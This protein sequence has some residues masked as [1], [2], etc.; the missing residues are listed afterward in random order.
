MYGM[1]EEELRRRKGQRPVKWDIKGGES[2]KERERE[3][4][5]RQRKRED[6][7]TTQVRFLHGQNSKVSKSN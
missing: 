7:R 4:E 1:S 6:I 3:I 2:Q 5:K